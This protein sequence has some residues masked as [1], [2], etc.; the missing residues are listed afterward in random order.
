[1]FRSVAAVL[2][3]SP[4]A[5]S[6]VRISTSKR[7]FTTHEQ[8]NVDVA[9]RGKKPISYCV[10]VS[11]VSFKTGNGRAEDV[12]AT[13]IPFYVQKLSARQKWSTLLIGPDVG[14]YRHPE[15]QRPG[16]VLNFHFRLSDAGRMRL[17]LHYWGGENISACKNPKGK[18]TT[19]SN[20]FIVK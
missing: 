17:V 20:V 16:Q 18:K 8:I 1:M 7:E 14:S 2:L 15:I 4:I 19:L 9:N 5:L 12:E 13:P 3:L 6:Q 11:Q 10:E